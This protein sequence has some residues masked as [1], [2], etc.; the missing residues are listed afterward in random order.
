MF[1]RPKFFH[2][3]RRCINS[4]SRKIRYD[5]NPVMRDGAYSDVFALFK[6]EIII[7][8]DWT[9]EPGYVW[10]TVLVPGRAPDVGDW[11]YER[12]T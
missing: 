2:L 5:V 3:E 8:V 4:D 11:L 9:I 10:Y 1:N 12:K 6:D 7:D